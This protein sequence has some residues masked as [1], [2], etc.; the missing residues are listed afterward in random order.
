MKLDC[1]KISNKGD[2]MALVGLVV[3][4]A[5]VGVALAL[6]AY[7]NT[8]SAGFFSATIVWKWHDW[9]YRPLDAWLDRLWAQ[10]KT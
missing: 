6:A 7:V 10:G 1:S 4:A 3:L 5:A 9:L 8:F 2:L